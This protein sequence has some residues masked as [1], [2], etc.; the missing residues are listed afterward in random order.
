MG[1]YSKSIVPII[2]LVAAA[3]LETNLV[4]I[5]ALKGIEGITMG[6]ASW[7]GVVLVKNTNYDGK[8]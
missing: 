1:K 5:E 8:W 6:I 4:S 7:L 2:T 3:L